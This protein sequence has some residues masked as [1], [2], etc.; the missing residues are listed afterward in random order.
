MLGAAAT[1]FLVASPLSCADNPIPPRTPE[2]IEASS[3]ASQ[4]AIVGT[5]VASVPSVVVTSA[6]GAPLGGVVVTFFLTSGEGSLEGALQ[7]TD[8][9]GV[10]TLT[11]WTLGTHA[12]EASVTALAGTLEPVV[13]TA[14]ATPDRATTV[15]LSSDS[16]HFDALGD[17]VRLTAAVADQYGNALTAPQVE[18]SV[19]DPSIASIDAGGLVTSRARGKTAFRVVS[20]TAQTEGVSVVAPR[21]ASIVV[22]PDS[23][24]LNAV[25]DTLRFAAAAR[26]RKGNLLDDA[27]ITWSSLETAI[28]SVDAGTVMSKASGVAR[29]V[30]ASEAAADTASL[31]VR[32]SVAGVFISPVSST[33]AAGTSVQLSALARDSNGVTIDDAVFIWA[34]SDAEAVEVSTSGMARGRKAGMATVTASA[35]GN[36]GRVLITVVPGLPHSLVKVGGDGQTGLAGAELPQPITVRVLDAFD[37]GVAGVTVAWTAGAGS[38]S[39]NTSGATTDAGGASSVRWT[40]GPTKGAHTIQASSAALAGS[41]ILFAAT[42]TPNGRITGHL[43]TIATQGQSAAIASMA[44]LRSTQLGALGTTGTRVGSG[45]RPRAPRERVT[46]EEVTRLPYVPGSLIVRF[47]GQ[48]LGVSDAAPRSLSRETTAHAVGREMRTRLEPA[49]RSGRLRIAGTSPVILAAR[50]RVDPT[51]VEAVR[52][53]LLKDPAVLTVEP[54]ALASAFEERRAPEPAAVPSKLPNDTAYNRQAWHYSMVDL[55]EAWAVTTG[56]SSVLVAVVDDGIRFNHPAIAANLTND[57]YDFVSTGLTVN[58]CGVARDNAGDGNGYDPNPTVPAR[59][60][61]SEP[62]GLSSAGGHGLHVAGTIGAVGNDVEGGTGVNWSVRIRPVRVL[63]VS[64]QGTVYDIAQGVLYAAGLA[65]DNGA[66][67]QVP[68]VPPAR[69]IN[70]SLGAAAD[71]AVLRDAIQA[72]SAAGV[73]VVASAGNTPTSTPNY[74][75][76]YPQVLSVTAVGADMQLASYSSFGPTVDIAGPG[77]DVSDCAGTCGVWSTTWNFAQDRPT[78][79]YNEGT[80]M[81]APH[82]SG[83]AALLLAADPSLSAAQLRERLTAYAVD[84]GAPGRDDQYGAGVVNARSSLVRSLAPSRALYAALYDAQTGTPLRT[85]R[86]AADAS[87]TFTGLDNG[88]Y[89]V[90]AGEDEGGD[91]AVG[92]PGRRWS[93]HGNAPTRPTEVRVS[94]AGIYPAPVAMGWPWETEPNDGPATAGRLVDFGYIQAALS[95]NADADWFVITLPGGQYVFETSAWDGAC[96]YALEAD[97]KLEL[98]TADGAQI[99]VNDN[100][101]PGANPRDRCSRISRTLTAGSYHLKVTASYAGRYRLAARRVQ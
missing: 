100:I 67:G 60:N 73:L 27:Q 17:T 50:I 11:R 5:D 12:G 41:A 69:I 88:S 79:S 84:V 29:I 37:N 57:G 8:A 15:K 94:G 72:A 87:Y 76:A 48:A 93:A 83:V 55:P 49:A 4:T 58:L 6:D 2:G 82:V 14:A 71:V 85:L 34:T 21:T 10:A 92:V 31:V 86:A 56:S 59:Y 74:P 89:F 43:T 13:F 64:G 101:D 3:P 63:G 9:S 99:D 28:A 46:G 36:T 18:W 51:Q 25:G 42:A 1:T 26:D 70:L 75:A 38:G 98:M 78:Y 7:T 77:G 54:D 22:T 97:T 45:A 61:C 68:T 53:E 96:G 80:S 52:A 47:R 40:L 35:A 91:G 90:F 20:D 24:T 81:A 44:R 19:A 39:A 32:Q 95:D 16:V 65:A 62:G 23:G 30:A 66:G 33:L